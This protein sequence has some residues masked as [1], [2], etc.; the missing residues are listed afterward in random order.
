MIF[1]IDTKR[2]NPLNWFKKKEPEQVDKPFHYAEIVYT[3]EAQEKGFF[4]EFQKKIIRW[5]NGMIVEKR[6]YSREE[7]EAIRK[8]Y[9]IPIVDR[10]N[11]QEEEFEF[12][13]LP[14]LEGQ[15]TEVVQA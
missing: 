1:Q 13:D 11:L 10:T 9:N 6:D 5:K 7:K 12:Q 4:D 2:L 8:V 14:A 3:Q 15:L